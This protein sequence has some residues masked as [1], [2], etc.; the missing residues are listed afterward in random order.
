MHG[1][2]QV[3]Y[4]T[5]LSHACPSMDR[6]RNGNLECYKATLPWHKI[7]CTCNLW[8]DM[9]GICSWDDLGPVFAPEDDQWLQTVRCIFF[10]FPPTYYSFPYIFIPYLLLVVRV[11]AWASIVPCLQ[12]KFCHGYCTHCAILLAVAELML[13]LACFACHGPIAVYPILNP[14]GLLWKGPWFTI[15][16]R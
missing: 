3:K 7:T 11:W 13:L 5:R 8:K 12:H 2:Q 14:A 6:G 9:H 4:Y 10:L 16:E 1:T 15:A